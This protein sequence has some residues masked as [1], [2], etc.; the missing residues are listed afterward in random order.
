MIHHVGVVEYQ[1]VVVLKVTPEKRKWKYHDC[2]DLR[3]LHT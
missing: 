1:N 2:E 3:R